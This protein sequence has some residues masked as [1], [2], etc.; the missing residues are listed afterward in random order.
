MKHT[1]VLIVATLLTS[2]SFA[3]QGPENPTLYFSNTSSGLTVEAVEPSIDGT[4]HRDST[5]WI[6]EVKPYGIDTFQLMFKK[7]GAVIFIFDRR[8]NTYAGVSNTR[9]RTSTCPI[10]N[11][12]RWWT[13]VG[14]H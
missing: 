8:A 3:S 6:S 11:W 7:C 13:I 10:H 12:E 4:T 2:Q 9:G 14:A 5:G 1:L